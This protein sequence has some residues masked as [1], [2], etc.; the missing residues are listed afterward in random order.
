M[1]STVKLKPANPGESHNLPYRYPVD[2]RNPTTSPCTSA[3]NRIGVRSSMYGPIPCKPM[4]SPAAVHAYEDARRWL[5]N[6]PDDAEP[7]DKISPMEENG[8]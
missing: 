4:G 6:E 5:V 8:R 3:A 7:I 2:V 1:H